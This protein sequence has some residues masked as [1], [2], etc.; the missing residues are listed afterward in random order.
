M[1]TY[2]LMAFVPGQPPIVNL[3]QPQ[4]FMAANINDHFH[5]GDPA[6]PNLYVIQ[7]IRHDV[8]PGPGAGHTVCRTSLALAPAMA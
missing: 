2:Q 1:V 3:Q 6:A 7:H 5:A 8:F 4:P